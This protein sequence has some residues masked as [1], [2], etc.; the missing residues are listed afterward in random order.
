MGLHP[1]IKEMVVPNLK[2]FRADLG[3]ADVDIQLIFDKK[4]F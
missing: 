1:M 3:D 4:L 2:K